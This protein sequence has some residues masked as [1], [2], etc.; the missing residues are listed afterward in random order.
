MFAYRVTVISTE[1][2]VSEEESRKIIKGKIHKY[3]DK[4]AMFCRDLCDGFYIFI[5]DIDE[6]IVTIGGIAPNVEDT[7]SFVES[8]VNYL[9]INYESMEISEILL[10]TLESLLT[11]ADRQ[12]YIEDDTE[13]L[14]K[15]KLND[16]IGGR[17]YGISYDESLIRDDNRDLL[18]IITEKNELKEVFLP[19][20]K[21]ILMGK[22][23]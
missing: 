15:N 7:G 10:E 13:I 18:K 1:C 5:S 23:D 12:E 22:A 9:N 4:S 16:I 11:K 8:Y 21:R 6:N 19:E 20:L 14:E 2:L 3:A 17:A